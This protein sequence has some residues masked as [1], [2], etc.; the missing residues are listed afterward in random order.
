MDRGEE[1]GDGEH[2]EESLQPESEGQSMDFYNFFSFSAK[3]AIY[4]ASEICRQFNNEFLEPEHIFYSI[5]NLRSCSAVQVLHRLNVNVPKL[6]YTIEAHLYEFS[7]SHKG[8]AQFSQRTLALLDVSFAEVRRLNHREIGTA[9]LLIALAQARGTVLEGLVSEHDL[10]S[11]RIRDSFVAHLRSFS[12]AREPDAEEQADPYSVQIASSSA[13]ATGSRGTFRF[14]LADLANIN[15]DFDRHFT[16]E[17]IMAL[18]LAATIAR[19]TSQTTLKPEHVLYGLVTL[20]YDPR[21][22]VLEKLEV[23]TVELLIGLFHAM[24]AD[25]TPI[26]REEG[27]LLDV[28]DS[29]KKLVAIAF[30]LMLQMNHSAIGPLHLLLAMFWLGDQKTLAILDRWVLPRKS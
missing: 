1:H 19:R 18:N 9:H 12:M 30:T 10:N 4:R 23:D 25:R 11:K 27:A 26:R 21:S 16:A 28:D 24:L 7:G 8:T 14:N 22:S 17:A 13:S 2:E 5:L 29:V 15:E 20:P 6:T 3:K